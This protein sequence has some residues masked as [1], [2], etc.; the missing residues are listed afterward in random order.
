V[1]VS[2][3]VEIRS[4]SN[5]RSRNWPTS[6]EEDAA[7]SDDPSAAARTSDQSV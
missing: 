5:A 6:R 7:S 2:A 1:S 4:A 3:D